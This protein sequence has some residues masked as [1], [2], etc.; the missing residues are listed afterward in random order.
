MSANIIRGAIY[1]PF[2]PLLVVAVIYFALTFTL[3]RVL[4]VAERRMNKDD[5]G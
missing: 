1:R 3:T 4:G 5:R 2:E